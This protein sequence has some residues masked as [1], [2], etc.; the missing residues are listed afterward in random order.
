MY[1]C[2]YCRHWQSS[3]IIP[4]TGKRTCTF[5]HKIINPDK[6][7]ECACFN[8]D[9]FYCE[10]NNIRLSFLNCLNRR[11]ND[12]M[13]NG[14]NSCGKCRQFDIDIKDILTDFWI[15]CKKINLTPAK[16]KIKRRKKQ[17]K[18]KRR[19]KQRKITRRGIKNA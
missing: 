8:P 10:K 13:L 18:I 2:I 19:N 3:T 16:R 6:K 4:A 1:K 9:Y 5:T 7:I 12:R 14:F 17:R 15:E 11:K